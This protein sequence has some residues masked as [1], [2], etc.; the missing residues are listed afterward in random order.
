MAQNV[1][2][3]ISLPRVGSNRFNLSHDV[4]MSCNMGLV[5]PTMC[6]ECLPGDKWTISSET[7]LRFAP[8]IAPVM[9]RFRVFQHYF[10]VPNR[11]LWEGWN[12]WLFQSG[13]GGNGGSSRVFPMLRVDATQTAAGQL[14]DYLGVPEVINELDVNPLPFAA[15][16]KIWH[17]YYRDQNLQPD[18][19]DWELGPQL[20]DGPVPLNLENNLLQLRRRAWRH[21]YFT[22]ALPFAQRGGDVTIPL[23]NNAAVRV[24]QHNENAVGDANQVDWTSAGSAGGGVQTGVREKNFPALDATEGQQLFIDGAEMQAEAASITDLRRAVALQQWLERNARS[25]IRAVEGL[26]AH[27]GVKN[28]DARMQRPEFVYGSSQPIVISEVLQTAEGTD[29][30]G[31]M[32]GHGVSVGQSQS[33]SYFTPE[34]GY[35]LCLMSVMPEPAYQQGLPRHFSKGIRLDRYSYAWPTFQHIG[36]QEIQQSEINVNADAQGAGR[37]DTF[38]YIPRYSEYKY[39]PSTVHG[40]FKTTLNHWHA[41]RIFEN[42]PVLNNQFVECDPTDRIFAVTTGHKIWAQVYHNVSVR[43][44]LAKFSNPML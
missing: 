29:P 23:T 4:K 2:N 10:F 1:F 40:D 9:H 39:I 34:H 6:Q 36:E 25:G 20:P 21:D 14:A 19:L 11:I 22:A 26:M 17:L 8:L 27:F 35:M 15:Y 7:M 38:G 41:G 13:E 24:W 12:E 44:P 30:V 37:L 42:N 3:S 28:K 31:N 43:R 18:A 5:V 32:A 16:Q 33:K